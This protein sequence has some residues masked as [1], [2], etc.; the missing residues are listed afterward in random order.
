MYRDSR[1]EGAI[2]WVVGY[3]RLTAE[4][5][6]QTQVTSCGIHSGPSG[7]AIDFLQVFQFPLPIII[8]PVFHI[9]LSSRGDTQ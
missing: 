8:P 2:A 3:Q 7:T 5:W 1:L 6:I 4:V 9:H